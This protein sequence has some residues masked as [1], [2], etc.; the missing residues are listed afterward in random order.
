MTI[1]QTLERPKNKASVRAREDVAAKTKNKAATKPKTQS[2]SSRA[3]P[4]SLRM[5]AA[6]KSLIDRAAIALGQSRTD[7][8][9]IS[10]RERAT[11]VLLNQSFFRLPGA[12]WSAFTSALDS[13]P[14]PNA[15]LKALLARKMP[16]ED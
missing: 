11:E 1:S 2:N 4:M 15:K 12:D 9:L 6:T 14:P 13:P 5:D 16:W 8:M 3:E 10:A 7:F